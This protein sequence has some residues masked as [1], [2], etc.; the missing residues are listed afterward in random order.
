MLSLTV[1]AVAWGSVAFGGRQVP[2]A[3]A[4]V[5]EGGQLIFPMDAAR[6]DQISGTAGADVSNT[7]GKAELVRGAAAPRGPVLRVAV[8]QRTTETNAVQLTIQNAVPVGAGDVM[9]AEFFVRGQSS[10]RRSPA[11]GEFL[12][13]QSTSPW[14][15]SH[16]QAFEALPDPARWRRVVIPF[17]SIAD[18]A[19]GAAMVSLRF[20]LQLQSIEIAGLR[21]LNYR[22]TQSI[23]SLTAW[24]LRSRPL[25]N[26][27]VAVDWSRT[28]QVMTGFG[29]NFCQPRYGETRPMDPVGQFLLNRL[30]VVNARIGLPMNFWNPS[31]GVFREDAQAKAALEAMQLF[32]KREIPL[33]VSVWTLPE[34]L[35]GKGE[36]AGREVPVEQ[37]DNLIDSIGR[38]LRLAKDKYGAE[39]EYFSFNEPDLGINVRF[40]SEAMGRF[41]K[42]A[43]PAWQRMGLRTRFLTADTANGS[44]LVGYARPLLEDPELKPLLGPIAF[45]NW[46]ALSASDD[47][48]RGIAELAQTHGKP[49]WCLEAGHDAQL[50]QRPNPWP[51]WRN[52]HRTA[53]AYERTI[54]LT[55]ASLMS[56]WTYQNNYPL[57]S[58]DGRTPFP[59]F[60]AIQ[61]MEYVFGAGTTVV[62]PRSP[63]PDLRV[64]GSRDR[65]SGTWAMLAI[66][67]AGAGRVRWTN[68]PKQ[69]VVTVHT[70]GPDSKSRPTSVSSRVDAKGELSVA[71][72]SEGIVVVQG[73]DR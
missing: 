46:D 2:P 24:A 30:Q 64:L 31:P 21:I 56:Y 15:K 27:V 11:R 49:V 33:V 47:A 34:H 51:T 23:E 3:R 62:E 12:F 5:P 60:H 17:N 10:D 9:L 54:R 19:P 55:R 13:E 53:L 37:W 38:F 39:A 71:I 67:T 29:G 1:A 7:I 26:P 4:E 42:R 69:T 48:Y 40:S 59:V 66:N 28:R 20:A 61:L 70:L 41:I 72:P 50:W 32:A 16:S 6:P 43:V 57:V 35:G 52:A 18:Y 44:A 65:R 63:S 8:R 73:T 58:A 45:H 22:Q 25:G 36:E 14:T 68:L